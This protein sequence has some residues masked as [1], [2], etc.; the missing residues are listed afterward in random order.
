M[1]CIL[2]LDKGESESF[3]RN[4]LLP[5]EIPAVERTTTTLRKREKEKQSKSNSEQLAR[6]NSSED[7]SDWTGFLQTIKS[8]QRK[9]HLQLEAE[10][11]YPQGTQEVVKEDGRSTAMVKGDMEEMVLSMLRK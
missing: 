11:F 6:E 5:C 10:E 2:K 9:E 8:A 3:H 7:E 4:M 1:R